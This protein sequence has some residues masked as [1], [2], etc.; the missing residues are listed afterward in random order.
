MQYPSPVMRLTE[1][2]QMGFPEEFLLIAYRTKGQDFAQK[3]NPTKRNSP[4]FFDTEKFEEYRMRKLTTE[5]KALPRQSP[6]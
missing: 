1:M 3:V 2:V 4:I 6:V 5:N